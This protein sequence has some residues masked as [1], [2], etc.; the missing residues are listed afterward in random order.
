[1]DLLTAGAAA[2]VVL[3]YKCEGR[4]SSEQAALAASERLGAETHQLSSN[5]TNAAVIWAYVADAYA[6]KTRAMMASNDG[7]SCAQL[8]RLRDLALGTGFPVPQ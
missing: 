8:G 1:M 3:H 2:S 7:S 4:A 5:G 6:I